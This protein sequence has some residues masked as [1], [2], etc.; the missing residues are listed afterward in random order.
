MTR[1]N[2]KIL[3]LHASSR[4][5]TFFSKIQKRIHKTLNDA[6]SRDQAGFRPTYSCEDHLFTVLMITET[7]NERGKPLWIATIDF[8]KAFDSISHES[9]W[10]GLEKQGVHRQY[11]KLLQSLY[12]GQNAKVQT[13]VTSRLFNISRGTKQGDPISPLLFNAVVEALMKDVKEKWAKKGWGVHLGWGVEEKMTNLR[14]ADDILL[15][16]RTLPQIKK[17]L[18]DVADAAGK[19]GLELH[20][21]KTK[22]LHNG[23]GYGTGAK[24][25]ICGEMKLAIEIIGDEGETEYLGRVLNM[26]NMHGAEMRNRTTRAWAKFAK[27]KAEL[28]CKDIPI[29]LRLKLFDAVVTPTMLYGAGAWPMTKGRET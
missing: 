23:I 13:D 3:G 19:V 27:H 2:P 6:Q 9:I 29:S 10:R 1:S 21:G 22:I 5:F 12:R 26:T 28:T 16:A 17:M 18:G 4:C 25:A 14:F 20:P 11:T 24:A 15:T 8:K 7:L